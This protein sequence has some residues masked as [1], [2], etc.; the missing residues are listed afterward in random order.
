MF[1]LPLFN[2]FFLRSGVVS[3]FLSLTLCNPHLYYFLGYFFFAVRCSF[4]FSL[5]LTLS[6]PP[7]F[8]FYFVLWLSGEFWPSGGRG[9]RGRGQ[10]A[11]VPDDAADEQPQGQVDQGDGEGGAVRQPG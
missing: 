7:C 11:D 5:S 3:A 1:P 8:L 6:N 2:F 10:G 9:D 4:G